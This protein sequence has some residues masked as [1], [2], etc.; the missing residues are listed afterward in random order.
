MQQPLQFS[1][2]QFVNSISCCTI[3]PSLFT[4]EAHLRLAW[5]HLRRSGLEGAIEAVEEQITGLVNFLGAGDKYNKTLTIAAV[6]TVHHFMRKTDADNFP[7][8]I[9]VFPRLRTHFRELIEAHYSFDIFNAPAAKS[10]Y[11]EPDL[12]PYE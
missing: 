1:D 2:D 11:L 7:D 4:H 5:I 3:D 10:G 6:K 8:F 12:L 9:A